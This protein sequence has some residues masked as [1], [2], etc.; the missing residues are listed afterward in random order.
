M[1]ETI[2]KSFVNICDRN[3]PTETYVTWP[4]AAT[5]KQLVTDQLGHC[6]VRSVMLEF[7]VEPVIDETGE[8]IDAALTGDVN[9]TLR[10][11]AWGEMKD[12][13]GKYAEEKS[14][15]D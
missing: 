11:V 13:E 3:L 1:E 5:I 8:Q 2:K 15:E 14:D 7:R 6:V 12:K 9:I 10:C 4:T